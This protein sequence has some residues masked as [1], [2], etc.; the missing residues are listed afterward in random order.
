MRVIGIDP[1][2][3]TTGYGVV[4]EESRRLVYVA[5]G[6]ISTVAK[7]PLPKRL[8]KI[9]DELM[10]VFQAHQP[11]A[12]AVENT[13]VA[14]NFQSALK[15][16][17]ARGIALLAAEQYG[18]PV[19]DCTPTEVKLAVVGYGAARKDQV[20]VMVGRL[21]NLKTPPDSH[22]AADALA[23]A[24]CFIHS[25]RI[26]ELTSRPAAVKPGLQGRRAHPP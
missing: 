25:A 13:F 10:A 8:K 23:V 20:E 6:S 2:T 24:I 4:D 11:S 1:G 12:V 18:V 16:G 21:L 14:K 3:V 9:Y 22:H 19:Y 17:Q 26:R 5:S 15:L 7:Q